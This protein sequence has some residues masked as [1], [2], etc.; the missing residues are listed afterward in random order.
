MRDF[1]AVRINH[2]VFCYEGTPPLILNLN[3]KR[4]CK[5]QL[6]DPDDLRLLSFIFQKGSIDEE[7]HLPNPTDN[8]RI[9]MWAD[10]NILSRD[11]PDKEENKGSQPLLFPLFREYWSSRWV[12]G[13]E[14]DLSHYHRKI[15]SDPKEQFEDQEITLSHMYRFSHPALGDLSYGQRFACVCHH[16]GILKPGARILEVGGGTGCFG[17]DFLSYVKE[18]YPD[19]YGTLHYTFFDLS[20]VL[21]QA[22]RER[23]Q[24]HED[25]T[26]FTEG[27]IEA[28][29]F[30]GSQFDLVIL[31]EMIADLRVE[32]LK[33]SYFFFHERP[34]EE[35]R[36]TFEFCKACG[37]NFEDA[38]EEFLINIGAFR[39]L[40][41]LVEIMASGGAAVVVEYGDMNIYPTAAVLKSHT[42]FS[43]HFGHLKHVAQ[44]SGFGTEFSDMLHF[45]G[46][47]KDVEILD[48]FSFTAL[49]EHFMPFFG[50]DLSRFA[51]T[52]ESLIQE[53]G[54]D[55]LSNIQ[56]L[57]FAPITKASPTNDPRTYKVLVLS[58]P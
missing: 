42:E 5:L 29:D 8:E 11:G 16:K 52:R 41:K 27:D 56:G 6:A 17:A 3:G 33:K 30:D 13:H 44:W 39:L 14:H 53:V 51:H 26:S 57:R 45:L 47:R 50:R 49:R 54:E 20:P 23:T 2:G 32:K 58:K 46:F 25:V 37:L 35:Q 21:L 31:N 40:Y 12:T 1:S 9:H 18:N 7:G 28:F 55:M 22:Q 19:I 24:A 34:P 36:G 43:I 10:Q 48:A 38:F 4:S 15:I